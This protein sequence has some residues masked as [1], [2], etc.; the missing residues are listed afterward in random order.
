MKKQRALSF[1]ILGFIAFLGMYIFA[2]NSQWC[3]TDICNGNHCWC[4]GDYIES[5]G[6]C[7]FSCWKGYPWGCTWGVNCWYLEVYECCGPG[8]CEPRFP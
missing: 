6:A 8:N 4:D 2:N 1:L 3:P 7:C 5:L